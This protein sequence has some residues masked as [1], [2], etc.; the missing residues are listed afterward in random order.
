MEKIHTLRILAISAL[1]WSAGLAY[2]QVDTLVVHEHEN[3]LEDFAQEQEEEAAFDYDEILDNLESY[4]RRPLDLNKANEAELYA[5]I[6]LTDVQKLAFLEYRN[7]LGD[8]ISIY[9]LQNIPTFD[10][11]TIRKILPYVTIRQSG[12]SLPPLSRWK[13]EGKSQLF[14]RFSRVLQ[15]Q[16]GY[17]VDSNDSSANRYLGDPNRLFMRYRFTLSPRISAGFTAEKDA[18]EEFF[19]GSNKYG[20][21]YYSAHLFL[22]NPEGWLKSLALGDFSV[23]LG[24]GLILFQGYSTG[25]NSFSTSVRK[26]GQ[27]IRPYSSVNELDFFRGMAATIRPIQ[28]VE[29]TAFG[30]KAARDGNLTENQDPDDEQTGFISSLQT[31]GLHRSPTEIADERAVR[32]S[33]VGTSIKYKRK[34]WHLALNGIY[35]HLS[36]PLYRTSAV[37]NRFYFSGQSLLNGSVDYAYKYKNY[38]FFGETAFSD[39]GA[40]ASLNGLMLIIDR[41][42][43]TAILHRHYPKDF[44][45]LNAKPFAE[46]AGGKNED[47]IYFGIALNPL[48]KWKL[49]AY[50]DFFEHKWPRYGVN[51]PFFGREWMVR[52]TYTERKKM[53]LYFQFKNEL[54]E[55]NSIEENL[56]TDYLATRQNFYGRVHF[57]LKA[58][59]NLEWRSRMDAGFSKFDGRNEKGISAFQD[60]IY[61]SKRIPVT[62]TT[63]FAVFDTESYNIRFYA[64]ENDLLYNFSIPAYYGRGSRFYLNCRYR[65]SN[66][67]TAEAR[68]AR[69][70]YSNVENIGSSLDEIHGPVKS[71]VKFQIRLGF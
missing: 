32:Q 60:L 5:F 12:F 38:F 23:S 16:E 51:G 28:N 10:L 57:S 9:E 11:A 13:E 62:L 61:Q 34:A 1:F 67:L 70:L 6:F 4:L 69:T 43:E 25:K 14:L 47:G 24:Q 30:S 19:K 31:S 49:N 37:Y 46:T 59:E 39:N 66:A 44:Q 45:A 20:F 35:N 50:L 53:E 41:R 36:K 33:T 58:G 8:F 3:L 56:K 65:I 22:Q 42:I 52:M 18:G 17:R 2:G 55:A 64:Y 27:V 29:I 63:R 26:G 15:T 54:K 71:E 40:F 21:D 7:R 68:Y 48:P